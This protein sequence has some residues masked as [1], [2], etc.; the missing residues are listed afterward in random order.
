LGMKHVPKEQNQAA[1]TEERRDCTVTC[2]VKPL[3]LDFNPQPGSA[4]LN[5]GVALRQWLRPGYIYAT[6][7]GGS[8]AASGTPASIPGDWRRPRPTA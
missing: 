5:V 8:P 3:A 6:A 1:E 4:L 2:S 7:R